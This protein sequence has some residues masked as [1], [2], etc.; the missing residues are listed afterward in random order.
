MSFGTHICITTLHLPLDQLLFHAH[1]GYFQFSIQMKCLSKIIIQSNGKILMIHDNFIENFNRAYNNL[2]GS[3]I[4]NL[5]S[6]AIP[7]LSSRKF[8]KTQIEDFG[9]PSLRNFLQGLWRSVILI[10]KTNSF[11]SILFF[12]ICYTL[13]P[14]TNQRYVTNSEGKRR[15][16]KSWNISQWTSMN[17]RH[18]ACW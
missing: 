15:R 14:S 4:R 3:S 17:M 11:I 5:W 1:K 7:T 6:E 8:Q 10:Q 9:W 12:S 18:K 16:P 13:K 2:G